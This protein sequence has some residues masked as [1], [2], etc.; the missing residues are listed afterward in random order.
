MLEMCKSHDKIRRD[1]LV[2]RPHKLAVCC[3]PRDHEISRACFQT[4]Q[5]PYSILIGM[6][7]MQLGM[8]SVMYVLQ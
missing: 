2:T 7:V 6:H 5:C 1:V 4:T 8:P 3:A